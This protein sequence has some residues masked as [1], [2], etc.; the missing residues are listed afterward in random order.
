HQFTPRG[1]PSGEASLDDVGEVVGDERLD[2]AVGPADAATVPVAAMQPVSSGS[3][4]PS[5]PAAPAARC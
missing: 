2:V 3:A 4:D 1:R 5:V